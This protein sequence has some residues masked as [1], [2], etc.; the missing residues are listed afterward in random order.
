MSLR[1]PGRLN[2]KSILTGVAVAGFIITTGI[3]VIAVQRSPMAVSHVPP[4]HFDFGAPNARIMVPSLAYRASDPARASVWSITLG[5]EA[6]VGLNRAQI[7][8][9][10]PDHSDGISID[11][12]LTAENSTTVPVDLPAN[13]YIAIR[14]VSGAVGVL[15]AFDQTAQ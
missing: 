15:S 10:S 9:I 6:R 11:V 5:A 13:W 14:P 4:K 8:L 2:A 1:L 7:M 12:I 3:Q